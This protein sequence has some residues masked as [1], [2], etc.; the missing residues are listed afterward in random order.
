[1]EL[2]AVAADCVGVSMGDCDP[3]AV[4]VTLAELRVTDSESASVG[5]ADALG[6]R[7]EGESVAAAVG[8]AVDVMECVEDGLSDEVAVGVAALAECCAVSD[9]VVDAVDDSD[10]VDVAEIVGASV[11]V[12]VVL[13][14]LEA[15]V[16]SSHVGDPDSVIVSEADSVSD[17][18]VDD[19][20]DEVSAFV[21]VSLC[22]GVATRVM[23]GSAVA[24]GVGDAEAVALPDRE[25]VSNAVGE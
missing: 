25:S 16:V 5:E 20:A 11:L 21:P 4:T 6:V 10:P 2:V 18:D 12:G 7:R 3:D 22:V 17:S 1:M 24:S 9:D 13:R 23:V 19:D 8:V 15:L 14:V